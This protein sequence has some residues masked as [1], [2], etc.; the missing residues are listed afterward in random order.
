[1]RVGQ[2]LEVGTQERLGEVRGPEPALYQN[3]AGSGQSGAVVQA[4]Q[5]GLALN[6][7][8]APVY[9]SKYREK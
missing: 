7:T 5:K 6:L 8:E 3:M 4:D 1:V 9:L 2:A